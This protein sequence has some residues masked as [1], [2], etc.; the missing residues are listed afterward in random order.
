MA[1]RGAEAA[2]RLAELL[3]GARWHR[4]FRKLPL[5]SVSQTQVTADEPMRAIMAERAAVAAT[6]GIVG[7]SVAVGYPYADVP[8]LGMAAVVYARDAAAAERGAPK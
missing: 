5:V 2:A 7:A 4:A 8:Q 1:E 6:P 3:A